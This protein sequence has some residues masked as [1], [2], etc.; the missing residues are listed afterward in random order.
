M[1]IPMRRWL[2]RSLVLVLGVAGFFAGLFF[3]SRWA[4]ESLR[5][6]DRYLVNLA[7][8]EC[9]APPGLDRAD[10]LAEVQYGANAPGLVL[11]NQF[12][13]LERGLERKLKE[14]FAQHPWVKQVD[15]VTLEPPRHIQ[16]SLT[17]RRPVLAVPVGGLLRAVDDQGVLLPKKAAT[18]GLPVYQGKAKAPQGE[19]KAWGDPLVERQARELGKN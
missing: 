6:E 4:L 8:I 1:V 19:G 16:V 12:S 10:F 9:L 3:L 15:Q 17:F 13:I 14:S 5:G 2:I 18:A 11:P 7:D